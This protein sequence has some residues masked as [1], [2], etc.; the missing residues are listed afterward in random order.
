MLAALLLAAAPAQPA[1]PAITPAQQ[2]LIDRIRS[3]RDGDPRRFGDCLYRWDSWKLSAKGVRTTAF[4]CGRET[5]SVAVACESLKLTISALDGAWESWRL[6][7]AGP[8]ELM[9]ATLC[10]NATPAPAAA[11]AAERQP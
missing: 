8:E 3:Q 4:S 5:R 11:S 10:A 1:M 7:T 9:V 2:L 6:P